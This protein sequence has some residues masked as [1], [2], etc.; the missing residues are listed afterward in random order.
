MDA[1][2]LHD[3]HVGIYSS[4]DGGWDGTIRIFVVIG[5][6][7]WTSGLGMGEK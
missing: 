4:R 2:M 1:Q 3:A 5:I 7:G 6:S